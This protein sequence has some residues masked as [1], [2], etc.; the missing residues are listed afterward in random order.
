MNLLN[1]FKAFIL[2]GNIVDLAVGIVIGAAFAGVVN[3][4]VKDLI[5]PLIGIFGNFNFPDLKFAVGRS[6]FLLGD[7]INALIAFLLIAL[8]IFFFVVK[9][10]N[11]LMA[12]HKPKQAEAPTTRE[13]PFCLSTVPLKA[14][15][16]AFC[17]AQLPPVEE[18]RPVAQRA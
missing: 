18:A 17:T 2:R 9:P 3:A 6:Q 14:T 16:C 4:L 13:C 8:V 5:T 1:E 10:V 15:R 7:F 11:L 12:L